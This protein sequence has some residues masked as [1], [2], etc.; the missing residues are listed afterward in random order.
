MRSSLILRSTIG[1]GDHWAQ[2]S[3]GGVMARRW[4]YPSVTAA[5]CHLPICAAQKWRGSEYG[6]P[7]DRVQ[8]RL[9]EEELKLVQVTGAGLDRLDQAALTD[10][11]S[12]PAALV[13]F[14]FATFA[15]AASDARSSSGSGFR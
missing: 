8:P 2:P 9:A 10:A 6:L 1:E 3:G 14:C 4:K 11:L 7:S 13:L 15:I 5:R 12:E